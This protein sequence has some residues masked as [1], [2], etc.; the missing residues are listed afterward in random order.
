MGACT[1]M[2]NTNVHAQW[3]YLSS[4]MATQ[5]RERTGKL[6]PMLSVYVPAFNP[7]SII[8]C[9]FQKDVVGAVRIHTASSSCSM[10]RQQS[11]LITQTKRIR[12]SNTA[13]PHGSRN[14]QVVST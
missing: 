4:A 13:A 12:D 11:Y 5:M 7:S 3:V 6:I 10:K 1:D 14:L 8:L 9:S 2:L